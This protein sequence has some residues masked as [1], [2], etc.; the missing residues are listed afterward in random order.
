MLP[1]PGAVFAV[2]PDAQTTLTQVEI[3][4]ATGFG[5]LLHSGSLEM[6]D[7]RID[8]SRVAA[9]A[10]AA[11]QIGRL[12]SM[13]PSRRPHSPSHLGRLQEAVE[14]LPEGVLGPS[15]PDDFAVMS[16]LNLGA[17][18]RIR[19]CWGT[20]LYAS[21]GAHVV[22]S[23][24]PNFFNGNARA[25]IF[26]SDLASFVEGQNVWAQLNGVFGSAP[27]PKA[28]IVVGAGCVGGIHVENGAFVKLTDVHAH[29]NQSFG[30]II[31]PGGFSFFSDFEANGNGDIFGLG[32]GHGMVGFKGILQA[33][34]FDS[35][36]NQDTGIIIQSAPHFFLFNGLSSNNKIGIFTDECDIKDYLLQQNVVV[37]GNT[38]PG[39]PDVV[40][41]TPPCSLPI[42]EAPPLPKG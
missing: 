22:L 31:G 23:G 13:L 5:V 42:P 19:T 38:G 1:S 16:T 10:E 11:R 18:L 34:F 26:A 41:K 29:G 24:G 8:G 30:V 25:G 40:L 4:G 12:V 27:H 15:L 36:A 21:G 39:S 32:L 9:P 7:S 14:G 28:G 20:G 37:S 2:H 6:R 17:F 3:T 33:Q 35:L